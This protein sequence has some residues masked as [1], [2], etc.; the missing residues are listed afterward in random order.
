MVPL[1][2][3]QGICTIGANDSVSHSNLYVCNSVFSEVIKSR[4][5]LYKIQYQLDNIFFL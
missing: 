2:S 1:Y 5:Y 3:H 4:R